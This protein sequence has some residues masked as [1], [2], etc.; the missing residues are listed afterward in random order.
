PKLSPAKRPPAECSCSTRSI[1]HGNSCWRFSRPSAG[2]S[3]SSSRSILLKWRKRSSGPRVVAHILPLRERQTQSFEPLRHFGP[4]IGLA[5]P[6]PEP[7]K[8]A[9]GQQA[10]DEAVEGFLEDRAPGLALP[11]AV[12][13]GSQTESK[14]RRSAGNAKHGQILR[15]GRNR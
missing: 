12:D 8:R 3:G 1:S 5:L 6:R 9:G 4:K 7:A 13:Q 15:A 14:E 2:A 10:I 11:D